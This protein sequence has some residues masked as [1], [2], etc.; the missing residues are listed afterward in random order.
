LRI[1]AL[2][3][4][5]GSAVP[6]AVCA[7]A[8]EV[9]KVAVCNLTLVMQLAWDKTDAARE[10]VR[11][12]R[13]ILDDF[14]HLDR[15]IRS[16]EENGQSQAQ[17]A[18]L[19]DLRVSVGAFKAQRRDWLSRVSASLKLGPALAEVVAAITRVSRAS[20]Y[21]LVIRSD[22][23]FPL[24]RFVAVIPGADLTG[25]VVNDILARSQQ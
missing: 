11:I 6:A 7:Q 16:L 23:A 2:M 15:E 9:T 14:A 21:S 12:R 25:D 18:K 4:I 8:Q 22:S 24:D 5:L 13:G 10:F 3:M 17:K 20:G 1:W 19:A